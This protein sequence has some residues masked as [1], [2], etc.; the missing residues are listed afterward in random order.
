MVIAH[1]GFPQAVL[2][3][4]EFLL[5]PA[6]PN[7]PS[8]IPTA[9]P[10]PEVHNPKHPLPNPSNLNPSSDPLQ[11]RSQVILNGTKRQINGSVDP[12]PLNPK[13]V[14]RKE[15]PWGFKSLRGRR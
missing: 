2:M 5:H 12:K 7:A 10:N 8:P 4:V 1:S 6:N 15:M 3:G 11:F 14:L 9:I 13:L